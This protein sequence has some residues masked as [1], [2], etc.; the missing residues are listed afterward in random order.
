MADAVVV[1]STTRLDGAAGAADTLNWLLSHGYPHL[2]H[3]AVV[4]I[5]NIYRIKTPSEAVRGL[6]EDFE[7]VVRAV[8]SIPFDAHLNDAGAIDSE[9]MNAATKRAYIEAAASVVD[10]FGSAGDREAH[11]PS[12]DQR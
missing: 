2:V 10:G 9:R 8:H 6:H 12:R 1:P 11:L 7:R 5:S 4:V 3:S